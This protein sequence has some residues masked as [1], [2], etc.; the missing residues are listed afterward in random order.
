MVVEKELAKENPAKENPAK[1][2]PAKE[3]LEKKESLVEK[4]KYRFLIINITLDTSVYLIN[5]YVL[6]SIF[7]V[8]GTN[9][10]IFIIIC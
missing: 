7:F 1:E 8:S 3:N 9:I 4:N 2:N 5:L 10:I 6:L